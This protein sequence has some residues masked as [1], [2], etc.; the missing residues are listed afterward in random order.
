M[1][2]AGPD[3]PGGGT[4]FSAKDTN[5]LQEN[6]W[7]NIIGTFKH[8]T[9]IKLYINGKLVATQPVTTLNL[10]TSTRGWTVSSVSNIQ[11]SNISVAN[12]QIYNRVLS[13]SEILQNYNSLKPRFR[14]NE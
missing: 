2:G 13:D 3:I 6:T 7:Y 5:P 11:F 4:G 1:I 8:G 9:E 14:L 10:R 12:L